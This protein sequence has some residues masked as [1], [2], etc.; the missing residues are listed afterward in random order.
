MPKPPPKGATYKPRDRNRSYAA[1]FICV[2]F[3]ASIVISGCTKKEKA[4]LP[5][6]IRSIKT[7][8]ELESL[9]VNITDNLEKIKDKI[10]L[11]R[12]M[13]IETSLNGT[14]TT[15]SNNHKK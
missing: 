4:D 7:T 13:W 15:N 8:E 14:L 3:I 10:N 9:K 11:L 12:N 1:L 6:N 5:P 2:I